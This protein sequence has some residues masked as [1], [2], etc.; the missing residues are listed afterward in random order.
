MGAQKLAVD[1]E[2]VDPRFNRKE[3]RECRK[4]LEGSRSTTDRERL[5][6]LSGKV[7]ELA[8][9]VHSELGPGMLESAYHSCLLYEL[10]EAGLIAESQIKLP[11]NYRGKHIDA[12]YRVDLLVER[13]VVVE[14]K[15]VDRLIP[16]HEAQLLSYLRMLDLRLG[17]LINF[18]C[19]LLRDGIKRIVND[20]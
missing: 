11:L 16:V 8:I 1:G 20:F 13:S 12:G 19:R 7:I 3:R 15:A 17:L 5:N 18:N 10:L 2:K 4:M 6:A 14:I 9:R